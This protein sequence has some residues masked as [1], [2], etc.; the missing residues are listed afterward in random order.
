MYPKRTLSF[1]FDSW[2]VLLWSLVCYFNGIIFN[3]R[4][5]FISLFMAPYW[6]AS[7]VNMSIL[8]YTST[9][10]QDMYRCT[11]HVQARTPVQDIYRCTRR[12][13]VYRYRCT[14]VQVYKPTSVQVYKCTGV[15][16]YRFTSVQVYRC[17]S[18]QVYRCTSVQVYNC[19]SG[20]SYT[21]VWINE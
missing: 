9:R 20:L 6:P 12:V 21:C 15:Q 10:V 5:R 11:Y 2:L 16:V 14:S 4:S 17:T 18:I 8:R 7:P 1:P 3:I 19:T 13:Q